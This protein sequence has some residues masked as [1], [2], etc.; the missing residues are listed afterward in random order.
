MKHDQS[1][2]EHI[3]K[4][5]LQGNTNIFR[6]LVNR[7][8]KQVFNIGMRFLRNEDDSYDFAQEVLIQ[9]YQ[10]LSMFKGLSPFRFWL[11]KLAYNMG[12]NKIKARKDIRDLEN[13]DLV[14]K[15][16]NPEGSHIETE[17]RKILTNAIRELP[18][19]YRICVDF[20][21]FMGM[22]YA[23]ISEITQIPVNTIKSNVFRAKK[24]LHNGLK[25][26]IAEEY[27]EM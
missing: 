5:V 22:S 9:A 1:T 4:E 26:T 12:I 25:G 23:E 6:I 10:K 18:E 8:Q 2:D 24:I 3:V 11:Y 7:Y 13:I 27:Y 16:K 14:S 19:P 20:Y 21:F 15:E 17:I